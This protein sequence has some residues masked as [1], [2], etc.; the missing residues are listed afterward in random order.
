MPFPKQFEG[1][2]GEHGHTEHEQ[3]E[4]IGDLR[5]GVTNAP[6]CPT[7]LRTKDLWQ[8]KKKEKK[9]TISVYTF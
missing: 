3:E 4:D 5:Q 8:E 2:E 6:E 7:Q 9:H 1:H